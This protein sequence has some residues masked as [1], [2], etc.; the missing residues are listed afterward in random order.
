MSV[1]ITTPELKICPCCNQM[2][3]AKDKRFN[4]CNQK[5]EITC[6]FENC[7][8]KVILEC[9]ANKVLAKNKKF[10]EYH[11]IYNIKKVCVVCGK[12]YL[13][14]N[15]TYNYCHSTKLKECL[16]CGKV[17][18]YVCNFN[19][20]K[21]KFCSKECQ[22]N[23]L[24]SNYDMQAHNRALWLN[25]NHRAKV[26]NAMKNRVITDDLK[27]KIRERQRLTKEKLD[28]YN[29]M[30]QYKQDFDKYALFNRNRGIKQMIKYNPQVAKIYIFSFANADYIKVGMC[31]SNNR[32][33]KWIK[34]G[35]ILEFEFI[36]EP[37]K[38]LDIEAHI[39]TY[40]ERV[41]Q[42]DFKDGKSEFHKKADLQKI[43]DFIKEQA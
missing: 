1:Y 39:H 16:E 14:Q 15:K 7:T 8:N 26:Q 18:E 42:V 9:T 35:G 43:I 41:W 36:D 2:F 25:E 37:L 23:N 31:F 5:R 6:E 10:C 4:L 24:H 19:G 22:V 27:Q 20:N 13:A 40:F 33:K 21:Q 32:M 29:S 30:I 28:I 11:K 12:H 34:N 38:I 17:F 3:V